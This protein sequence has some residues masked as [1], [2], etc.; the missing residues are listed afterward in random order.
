[1][2]TAEADRAYL[3]QKIISKTVFGVL[4]QAVVLQRRT[5]YHENLMNLAKQ[6]GDD[7]PDDFEWVTTE[8]LVVIK[9]RFLSK[10]PRP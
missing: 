8:R 3:I 10:L 2:P 9:V 5:E 7:T 1:M 6:E 4:R